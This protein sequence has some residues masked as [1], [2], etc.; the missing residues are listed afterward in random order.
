MSYR[1][2]LDKSSKKFICPNCEK[3]TFVKYMDYETKEYLSCGVGKCDRMNKCNFHYPPKQYFYDNNQ[4]QISKLSR[5]ANLK[6]TF[7]PD[8]NDFSKIPKESLFAT[9]SAY[10]PMKNHFIQYLYNLFSEKITE[11]LLKKFFIGTFEKWGR[12]ATVFWQIDKNGIIR[13]SKGY[14]LSK[15]LEIMFVNFV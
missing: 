8:K 4:G 9:L 13:K 11:K 14:H 12:Y 2:S 15:Y 10:D 7:L 5:K 1:Y 3:K 6:N